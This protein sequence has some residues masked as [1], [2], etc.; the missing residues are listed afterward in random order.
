MCIRTRSIH[1][2]EGSHHRAM[3][4]GGEGF[5]FRKQQP[6]IMH[7]LALALSATLFAALL[8]QAAS[9]KHRTPGERANRRGSRL[10][11]YLLLSGAVRRIA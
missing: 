1:I 6:M 5:N 8:W 9:L 3:R 7:L 2:P 4:H 11:R 10:R